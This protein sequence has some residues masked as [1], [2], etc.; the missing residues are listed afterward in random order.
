MQEEDYRAEVKK[1]KQDFVRKI[2]EEADKK[3]SEV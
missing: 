1:D 3:I 2:L